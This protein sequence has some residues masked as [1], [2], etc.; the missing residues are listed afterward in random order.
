M[1]RLQ[2]VH[3]LLFAS[4]RACRGISD[5]RSLSRIKYIFRII[6]LLCHSEW[7]RSRNWRISDNRSLSKDKTFHIVILIDIFSIIVK[8]G[9]VIQCLVFV[10]YALKNCLFL[11]FLSKIFSISCQKSG[12]FYFL[13]VWITIWWWIWLNKA[14]ILFVCSSYILLWKK[15]NDSFVFRNCVTF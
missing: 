14:V 4:F 1:N 9:Y 2:S 5:N 13:L 7:R 10:I 6:L 11:V 12:V 8:N 3:S 15:T